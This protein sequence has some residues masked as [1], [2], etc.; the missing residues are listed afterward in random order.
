MKSLTEYIYESMESKTIEFDFTDLENAEETLKSFEDKEYC[1]VDENKLKVTINP[2]NVDK[3]DE[4]Q[5]ILQQYCQTI[6]S[7][8]KS[9][10][11]EQYAQKTKKFEQKVTEFNDAIDEIANPEEDE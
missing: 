10:N 4:V 6:R 7:S 2:D 11:D 1:E 9:T 8:S 5:D 3:L